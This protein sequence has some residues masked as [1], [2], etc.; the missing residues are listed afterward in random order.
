M[1]GKLGQIASLLGNLPRMQ[2]EMKK[3]REQLGQI[4]SEGE[5][6]GGAVKVRV[7][8]RMEVL[9]CQLVDTAM[10]GSDKELLE[11]LIKAATN[12][13]LQRV[14]QQVAEAYQKLMGGLNLP[15]MA[16]PG[17]M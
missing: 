15:G 3:L 4:I 6:G 5:A 16:L 8:G 1:F 13:A 11:D 2:E 7:N 14:Q 12:Q 17:M 9:S 10:V